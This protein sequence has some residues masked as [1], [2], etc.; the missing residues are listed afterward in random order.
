MQ[1]HGIETRRRLRGLRPILKEWVAINRKL[2]REWSGG[3]DA[4]WWY[5]ERASLSV[6]AGAVWRTGN[7]SFEEYSELKRRGKRLKSGRIDIWFSTRYHDFLGEAKYLQIGFT[8]DGGQIGAV[9]EKMEEA[10]DD[11]R[12][13]P[14]DGYT[15]LLAI[16]FGEP[17]LARNKKSE[18]KD[19]VEWLLEQAR[20]VEHDAL[21]WVFP[22]L[23]RIPGD[24]KWISPGAIVWIKEARR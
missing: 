19:R 5:N 24:D 17:Y 12:D 14:P 10:K 18:L 1:M 2:G 3:N 8:K 6:F 21:A 23:R 4:P 15:R 7:A 13:L 22:N 16:V 20:K 11:A 9:E